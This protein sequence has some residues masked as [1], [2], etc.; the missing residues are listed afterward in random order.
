MKTVLPLLIAGALLGASTPAFA[1]IAVSGE[2][3]KQLRPDDDVTGL[4]ADVVSIIDL[5]HY[6]PKTIA[7]IE[8]PASMVGPPGAVAVAPDESFALVTAAQRLDPAEQT[9][10][11]PADVVTLIDLR[12]PAAPRIAQ[13]AHAAAGASGVA[14]DRRGALAAVASSDDDSI[15]VFSIKNQTLTRLADVRLPKG[16]RPSDL[17]FTADGTRLVVVRR[18]DHRV[19]ILKVVGQTGSDVGI[20]ATPGRTPYGVAISPDGGFAYVSILGGV[21]TRAELDAPAPAG[22]GRKPG[23]LAVIDLRTNTVV[24]T[25]ELGVTPETVVLSADGKL[26]AAVIGNGASVQ[27]LAANYATTFG[28]LRVFAVNGAAVTPLADLHNGHWC[29]GATFSNDGKTLL[30]QCGAERTIETYRIEG[31]QVRLD[32]AATLK[33]HSRGGSIATARSR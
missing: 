27:K 13:T 3:G 14:I 15:T 5:N 32:P 28:L 10:L 9:K 22:A 12:K 4:T 11:L 29:Q 31:G 30:V 8:A 24:N 18:G 23:A 25:V 2:D 6:P 21:A 17:V 26:L 1:Q 19:S 20:E 16:S 33:T 7:T